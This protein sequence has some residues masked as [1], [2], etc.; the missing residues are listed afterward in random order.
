MWN[1]DRVTDIEIDELVK[2]IFNQY[3]YALAYI[4]IDF[5]REDVQ[6]AL[7]SCLVGMEEAFQ[8]T[9]DYWFWKRK[10]QEEFEY[11]NAFLIK[12]LNEQWKPKNWQDAYLDHPAFKSP[13]QLWWEEAAEAWGADLRNQLVADVRE[14]E[15]GSEE[16][17]FMSGRTLGLRRA[18]AWGWQKVLDYAL[19][20]VH[21]YRYN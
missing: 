20:G 17:V 5:E 6:D 10:I 7:S 16:I 11:P 19:S 4:G 1:L 13:C 15:N 21:H 18:K 3:K 2:E 8:A 9:I 12:A 14:T